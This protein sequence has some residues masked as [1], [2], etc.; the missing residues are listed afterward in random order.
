LSHVSRG[1]PGRPTLALLRAMKGHHDEHNPA[2]PLLEGA[3]L[4]PELVAERARLEPKSLS[5]ERAAAHL[6]L[7][8][9][10]GGR[11]AC[12][13]CRQSSS[14]GSLSVASIS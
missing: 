2:T 7:E 8:G 9:L 4:A 14:I 1:K 6:V 5:Y 10:W 3:R 13:T 12:A 11:N